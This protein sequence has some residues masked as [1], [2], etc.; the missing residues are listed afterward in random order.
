MEFLGGNRHKGLSKA[1]RNEELV[2]YLFISPWILGFIL[3]TAYPI[4]SSFYL[5]LCNYDI[6]NPPKFIGFGNYI[7]MFIDDP[8]FWHSLEVTFYYSGVSVPL[9]IIVALF[10]ALLLNRNIRGM[11]WFR[12]A[13]YTPAVIS[14]VA[15]GLLW[16]QIFNPNFGVLN[17][18]LW[19]LFKIQGPGWTFSEEWVIPAFIIVSLW[20]VGG[21][22]VI[23]LAGLQGIPTELYEAAE[24]DGA[25]GWTKIIKITLPLMSPIILFNLITGIIGSFQVFTEAYVMTSGGPH[26][27]SLFYNLYLFLNAFR[28]FKMGYAASLAWILFLIILTLTLLVFRTAPKWVHYE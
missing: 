20:R 9:G 23:Y 11:R 13:Y 18:L 15:V 28:W 6:I 4:F 7:K 25:T 2:F 3:F 24:V 21:G 17:Y 5:S 16:A 8:L 26:N 12:T 27:A 1:L 14:G 22:I 19:K 10:L